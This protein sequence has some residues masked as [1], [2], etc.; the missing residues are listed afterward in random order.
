[1]ST[2]SIAEYLTPSQVCELVPGLSRGA[3][4]Q[5]RFK[6]TGPRYLKP[7]AKTILYRRQDVIDWLEASERTQTGE[8]A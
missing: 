5:M 1:M 8:A 3:L 7:L 2:Q 6:G 4:S